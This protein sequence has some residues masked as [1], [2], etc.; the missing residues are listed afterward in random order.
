MERRTQ[1]AEQVETQNMERRSQ[2]FSQ[3]GL[4]PAATKCLREK[5]GFD[6]EENDDEDDFDSPQSICFRRF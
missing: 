6:E 4:T 2:N 1:D 5:S 3:S